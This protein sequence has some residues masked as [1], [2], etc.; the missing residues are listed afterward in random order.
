MDQAL[1]TSC[2]AIA[3]SIPFWSSSI[4]RDAVNASFAESAGVALEVAHV[5]GHPARESASKS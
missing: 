2:A 4:A 5:A 1:Q 3:Y